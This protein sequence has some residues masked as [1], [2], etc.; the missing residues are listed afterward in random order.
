MSVDLLKYAENYAAECPRHRHHW[1]LS[2]SHRMS[3]ELHSTE[4]AHDLLKTYTPEQVRQLWEN[5][6]FRGN[7][8]A[9]QDYL[10]ARIVDPDRLESP[11]EEA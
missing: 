2:I 8:K 1:R 7:T 5:G 11:S 6:A 10:F 3:I 4:E 9:L